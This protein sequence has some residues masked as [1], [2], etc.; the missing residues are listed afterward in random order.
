MLSELSANSIC[1]ISMLKTQEPM[2]SGTAQGYD[3]IAAGVCL[4]LRSLVLALVQE[5]PTPNARSPLTL[6]VSF[7]TT[8]P[9]IRHHRLRKKKT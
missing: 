3:P 8:H 4:R 1:H 2:D 7:P 6:S 9:T 5:P